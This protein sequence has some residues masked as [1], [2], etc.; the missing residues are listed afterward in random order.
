MSSCPAVCLRA[1]TCSCS[2]EQYVLQSQEL[3]CPIDGTPVAQ[4]KIVAYVKRDGN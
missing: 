4:I 1:N 3:M 2:S